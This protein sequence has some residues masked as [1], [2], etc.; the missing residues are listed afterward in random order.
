MHPK[1]GEKIYVGAHYGPDAVWA[2]TLDGRLTIIPVA[3]TDLQPRR[4]A[5]SIGS[6]VV[7]LDSQTTKSLAEF[8][9]SRIAEIK[10]RKKIDTPQS[11]VQSNKGYVRNKRKRGSAPEVKHNGVRDAS[12]ACRT[13]ARR[14]PSAV[15]E[16]TGSP[17]SGHQRKC[18]RIERQ[19]RS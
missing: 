8:V 11:S 18:G 1:F 16:Q 6:K 5:I 10:E 9:H 12:S 2:E 19:R 13:D 15:V 7:R 14:D 17:D 3:W 4:P